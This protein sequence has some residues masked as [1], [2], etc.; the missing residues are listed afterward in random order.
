MRLREDVDLCTQITV[1]APIS[2]IAPGR[3]SLQASTPILVQWDL[4]CRIGSAPPRKNF[5]FY[6][7]RCATL[8]KVCYMMKARR[9]GVWRPRSQIVGGAG[10]TA[11]L[12]LKCKPNTKSGYYGV[13]PNGQG[14]R[15]RLYKET[16]KSWDLGFHRASADG[17]Y[18][19][20]TAQEAASG[21]CCGD[22]GEAGGG[23]QRL[24]LFQCP[25]L[26]IHT[27]T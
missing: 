27:V 20:T 12:I 6:L 24:F 17:T 9:G 25:S 8:I 14:W 18:S 4:L 23:G 7:N 2:H 26:E 21:Y 5:L 3:T 11:R 10:A 1:F 19:Y 13:I 16:K 22:R 15:A